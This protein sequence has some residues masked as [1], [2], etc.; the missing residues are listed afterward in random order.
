MSSA[1]ALTNSEKVEK[2]TAADAEFE[3]VN[4]SGAIAYISEF[5]V[6]SFL[7]PTHQNKN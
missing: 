3:K 2:Q 1:V 7:R 4:K 5:A 6:R